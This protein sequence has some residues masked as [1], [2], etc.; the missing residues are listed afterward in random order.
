MT[1][2]FGLNDRTQTTI[3]LEVYNRQFGNGQLE[4]QY[5]TR[6]D[7]DFC[8]APSFKMPTDSFIQL[9]GLNRRQTY[10]IRAREIPNVAPLPWSPVYA[11]TT[12]AG[13]EPAVPTAGVLIQPAL[14]VKPMR[15]NSIVAQGGAP[16]AGFPIENVFVH[17]P[18]AA[19]RNVSPNFYY[20]PAHQ[21]GAYTQF[22]I[23][24]D[25]SFWDTIAV[26]D[27]NFSDQA[28]I[29][30]QAGNADLSVI[31]VDS[32]NVSF[33]ASSGL[34][35]RRGYHGLYRLS[36]PVE[37][38]TIRITIYEPSNQPGNLSHITH[39]V[40]GLGKQARNYSD[41]TDQGFDMSTIE[42]QRDGTLDVVRG[43]RGRKV[44]FEVSAMTE[45]T[46]ETTFG[47]LFPRSGYTE[48][49]LVIPNSKSGPFLHDR[50]LYGNVTAGRQTN[51]QM[52]FNRNFS[53]ESIIN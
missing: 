31:P 23:Q 8:I 39:V 41:L 21:N 12:Q 30:I 13:V 25:G 18:V 51:Q 3:R 17:S 49:M 45:T 36:S 33:R 22:T 44:D 43:F 15:V 14:F 7:M 11:F 40:V 26:L 20:D 5:G 10:Y 42:R 46:F 16:V 38:G 48:P 1:I 47:D 28:V 4:V 52:R 9:P 2:S 34:S 35:G 19:F 29:R 27:T 32:Q 50:M 6:P 24:T 37:Y 53:V